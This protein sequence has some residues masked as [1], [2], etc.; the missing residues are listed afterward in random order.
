MQTER[1]EGCRLV[2]ADADVDGGIYM[3]GQ[4]NPTAAE[5]A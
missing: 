5:I 3:A 1:Q 4:T 2:G